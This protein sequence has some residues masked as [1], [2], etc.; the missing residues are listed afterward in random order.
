MPKTGA[1][2]RAERLLC[3]PWAFP[4]KSR[5]PHCGKYHEIQWEH[6]RYDYEETVVNRKKVY[7]VKSVWYNCPGCGCISDEATMKKAP[8]RW[9]ADN[10]AAYA[11]GVR[12]FWLN[13]FVSQWA[14]WASIVLKYL[15]AI[16]N[17]RKLQVVY[18][19]CFGLLWED[20]GDLEDEDSLMARRDVEAYG[21]EDGGT[22]FDLPDG[23]LVLTAGVDTQ[24]DR[25]E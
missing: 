7:K 4:W 9:E 23:V 14:S 20:R 8:A 3:L 6:I 16:G 11:Q 1:E 10:P 24:D 22:P 18:N 19:T 12:S 2:S 21:L 25:M 17:T 13:A 15:N 5:C